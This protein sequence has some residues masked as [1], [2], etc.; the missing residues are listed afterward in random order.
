[1]GYIVVR[2]FEFFIIYYVKTMMVMG[3]FPER[4]LIMRYSP[5]KIVYVSL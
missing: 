1:M 5:H 3:L 4:D 2:R